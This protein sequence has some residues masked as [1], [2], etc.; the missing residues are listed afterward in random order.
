M[1]ETPANGHYK[2]FAIPKTYLVIHGSGWET[3]INNKG[4]VGGQFKLIAEERHKINIKKY[5]Y[6]KCF[7]E[8]CPTDVEFF[9]TINKYENIERLDVYSHGWVGG[10]NLGGFREKTRMVVNEE[11]HYSHYWGIDETIDGENLRLV[12]I[13]ELNYFQRDEVNELEY[14][15]PDR[16][17][18]TTKVYLWGCD[19]GGQWLGDKHV[20]STRQ[21]AVDGN[22]EVKRCFAQKF[23]ER[24]GKGKVYALKGNAALGQPGGSVFKSRLDKAGKYVNFYSDGQMLPANVAENAKKQNIGMIDIDAEKNHMW[25][26]PL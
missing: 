13:R 16:F 4:S 26:F 25:E 2:C 9:D 10:L 22:L 17:T 15:D 1:N 7:I 19:I 20:L 21:E 24:I 6:G 12:S 18:Y 5:P 8:Y 11:L 23:A 3:P 14:I